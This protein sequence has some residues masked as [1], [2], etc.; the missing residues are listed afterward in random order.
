MKSLAAHSLVPL[1]LIVLLQAQ[2]ELPSYSVLNTE[3][4]D[5]YLSRVSQLADQGYRVLAARTYT[6][7]HLEATPPD[8][9]RY[10]RFEVRGG[11]A[12]FTNWLNE[13]GAHGYR[14]VPNID[15]LEK[16]PHPKNYEYRNS[17]H[18]GQWAPSKSHEISLV[19]SE[20]YRP[21]DVVVF[22]HDIGASTE[23]MYFEREVSHTTS[24]RPQYS[25][26]VEVTEAMRVG[27][28][29]NRLNELAQEGYRFLGTHVSGRGG[30]MAIMSEKCP[31]G[32]GG[33]YEYRYFDAKNADQ[34]ERE[35]NVLGK[36][37]FRVI[38]RTLPRRPHL[39]ERNAHEKR[40]FSYRALEAPNAVNLQNSLNTIAQEGYVPIDFVWHSGW[41]TEGFLILEKEITDSLSP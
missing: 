15:L 18:R 4:G 25:V 39:L 3:R 26:T 29:T 33:H 6:V 24:A 27:K 16:S 17:P 22:T 30:G 31:D 41:T 7:L 38:P 12:Q 35:L 9:Y 5:T 36:D 8:T 21:S 19:I 34:L 37:G 28:I 11:P 14:W 10:A 2:N 13:Q 32:C 40:A 1:L 23:E 20:G